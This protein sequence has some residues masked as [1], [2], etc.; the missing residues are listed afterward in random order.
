VMHR[1]AEGFIVHT[2]RM[3]TELQEQVG[4]EAIGVIPLPAMRSV[5]IGD[6]AP[7]REPTDRQSVLFFGRIWPYKGLDVLVEAMEEVVREV[8]DARLVIAGRG[9]DLDDIF[10]NGV[11]PWVSLHN[12]F[13]AHE[14]IA[15]FF[16]ASAVVALPYRDATQS[17]VGV[18]AAD[19]VRPVVSTA[20]GGLADLF[21][22]NRGGFLVDQTGSPSAL[23]RPLI[24]LLT[25]DVAYTEAQAGLEE[26]FDELDPERVAQETAAFYDRVLA[27]LALRV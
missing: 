18:M 23:V 6:R 24:Q 20:V 17:A 1:T 5:W 25:N 2:D 12:R 22:G 27:G 3:K 15:E 9:A 7:V 16:E 8:P 26:I 10:A 11:P 4:D 13:V 14:E 19:F 21:A